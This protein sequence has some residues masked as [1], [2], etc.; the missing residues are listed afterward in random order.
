MQPPQEITRNSNSALFLRVCVEK[1]T[2][3]KIK[4]CM[5]MFNTLLTYCFKP[6]SSF[7]KNM[8]R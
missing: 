6:S 8:Q 3:K 1:S 2:F 4:S 5:H 7:C